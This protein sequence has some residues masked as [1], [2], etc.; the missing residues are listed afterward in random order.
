MYW[1][2][3]T[4]APGEAHIEKVIDVHLIMQN[5]GVIALPPVFADPRIAIDDQRIDA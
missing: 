4:G 1:K 2:Y 3:R 5:E